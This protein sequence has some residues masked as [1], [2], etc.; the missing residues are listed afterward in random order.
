MPKR[1]QDMESMN[2]RHFMRDLGVFAAG[3]MFAGPL[4]NGCASGGGRKPNFVIL[5]TDDMGY[6][7]W[8]R[9]GHPTINTPNLNKM[10]DEGIQLTQFYSANPVCSPSRSA[11]LTGRNPIRTGVVHVFVPN[12]GRGM[13]ETEIA[14]GRF[15]A[16]ST[17]RHGVRLL[18]R[19]SVQQRYAY[20]KGRQGRATN[21]A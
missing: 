14:S 8:N 15:K 5:F 9:G 19:N 10:A 1:R 7:D 20:R 16:V 6:G 12:D 3:S 21:H 4:L 11:L 17:H 2:R 18:L 13:P